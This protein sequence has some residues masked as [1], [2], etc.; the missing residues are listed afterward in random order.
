MD[1]LLWMHCYARAVET[2]SFSAVA[3]E[4]SIG[5]PNVSRHIAS[6]ESHLGTRLLH[7]STRKLTVTPE[8]E[9]YYAEVRRALDAIAEAESNAR[10]EDQPQGLLRVACPVALAR[11]KLMPLVKQFLVAY[12]AIELDLHV[13]D[14]KV[15]LIEEGVDVAIRVGE[16]RDSSLRARR[17]GTARRICVASSTYLSRRGVPQSPEELRDHNCIRYSLLAT[18][19]IWPFERQ[20]VEVRGNFR[21]D[22]PEAVLAA[23]LDGIGIGLMPSWLFADSLAAGTVRQLLDNWEIPS[24]PVNALYPAKRL[25]PRRAAAFMDFVADAFAVDEALQ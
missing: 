5:Q 8:G 20:P 16:L 19:T 24:L 2:G 18:G 23:V 13:A 10:G 6:L 11:F 15:D 9:R 12:P 7:R 3:R 4:L 1:R 21:V 14:R 25:M 22:S 17:L